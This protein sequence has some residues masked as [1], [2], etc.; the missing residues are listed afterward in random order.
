MNR[1]AGAERRALL[2]QWSRSSA[3]EP[4]RLF[5]G[6]S[7]ENASLELASTLATADRAALLVNTTGAGILPSS[8]SIGRFDHYRKPAGRLGAKSMQGAKATVLGF[9]TVREK[10]QLHGVASVGRFHRQR[11]KEAIVRA[12][13]PRC[14]DCRRGLRGRYVETAFPTSNAHLF[15]FHGLSLAPPGLGRH[16]IGS[17]LLPHL[18]CSDPCPAHRRRPLRCGQ[19]HISGFRWLPCR[20]WRLETAGPPPAGESRPPHRRVT[21][22]RQ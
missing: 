10:K 8:S 13:P 20:S 2:T 3:T 22:L 7:A 16:L 9:K 14:T 11:R 19:Q 6:T 1:Q 21:R 5:S 18:P 4:A 17:P 12:G 15:G